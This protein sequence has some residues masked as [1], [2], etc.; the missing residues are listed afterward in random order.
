MVPALLCLWLA[1]TTLWHAPNYLSYFNPIAGGSANGHKFL[2]DSNVDWGQDLIQL[3]HW[4]DRNPEAAED[5]HLAYF[6]CYDPAWVGINYRLPPSLPTDAAKAPPL[7][8]I[9]MG[10]LPGWYVVSKNY[11]AGH[12]MP[13]PDGSGRMHFKF[14]DSPFCNYLSDFEPVASI[15][16][17][18]LVYHLELDKVN[19]ARSSRGMA[20][21]QSL[22][23]IRRPA[24]PAPRLVSLQG[25][26]AVRASEK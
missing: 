21:I 13:V 17:S 12:S 1:G 14:F 2:C 11:L 8:Q 15:G 10:P 18:M 23:E 22:A 3:K 7:A 9:G 19:L 6:G 25:S 4:L 24:A 16:D 26:A 20:K 5:L